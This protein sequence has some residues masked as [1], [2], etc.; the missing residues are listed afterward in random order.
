MPKPSSRID[1]RQRA[2]C[3]RLHEV[4][5]RERLSQPHFGNVAG[6]TRN[7][8]AAIETACTPVSYRTG[9][10]VCQAFNLCQRWLAEGAEPYRGNV[11][12]VPEI[13]AGISPRCL[14]SKAYEDWIGSRVES[15]LR[16]AW[17]GS[18]GQA[19]YQEAGGTP[20]KSAAYYAGL[21][22]TIWFERLSIEQ[23][24]NLYGW[25]SGG[26]AMFLQQL[27]SGGPNTAEDMGSI[28]ENI[29]KEINGLT[30]PSMRAK[31]MPVKSQLDN[32]LAGL[33][34]LIKEQ[35]KKTE[36][37]EYLGAPLAS[38]SRWL[39]GKREPGR[40]ITLK[41]LRWV[42]QQGRQQNALGSVTS[43]TKGK[44]QVR[45]SGY[46]QTKSSPQKR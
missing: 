20:Q 39:S 27:D 31:L 8:V 7:M 2:I 33:E 45:K 3:K 6:L 41:M 5:L 22:Q 16:D 18:L 28:M 32:L 38:V 14:F 4:R 37:A 43:T 25:L 34:R 40:K 1:D 12:I 35:G 30:E 23:Q 9:R 19:M 26:A 10:A 42:E 11:R 24:Q 46:E 29:K 17:T 13:E 36:L 21:L 15:A 44:T